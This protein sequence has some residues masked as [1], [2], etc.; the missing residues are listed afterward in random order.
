MH[1][2]EC[3]LRAERA[4][5]FGLIGC[6]WIVER[7]HAP[8]MSSVGTVEVVAVADPSPGR[9]DVVGDI[10]GLDAS[11]RHV[12]YRDLLARDDIEIVSIATPPTTHREIVQAAA[13]RGIH[14]ICEKPLATNLADCDAML[15]ACRAASV[16]L[17][18]YHN[19]LYLHGPRK[20]RELIEAGA[21][22]DVLATRIAGLALRPWV[23]NEA[24]RPG[25]RFSL[26]EGG[27]GALMDVGPHALYL[28]EALHGSRI[29]AV[30]AAMHYDRPGVDAS[31]FCELRLASGGLANVQVG[32][33]H[34][35]GAIVV[36]GSAGHL[37]VVFDERAGYF[38]APARA[39]RHVAGDGE[40][41]C[42]HALQQG[43]AMVESELYADLVA[44]LSG[45]SHAYP[46]YGEDGR[47]ALE[48]TLAAYAADA[49]HS[50]IQLPVP[51]D[52]PLYQRG[53]AAL[54]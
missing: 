43:Y 34:G 36:Y 10:L 23:G 3:P 41:T 32:W 15:E 48:V 18:V 8:T 42:T 13:A 31:A 39:I 21:V 7:N 22:G 20:L 5:R 26:D 4:V 12:D 6:G 9:T 33:R 54:V 30:T 27:G 38:G 25:W 35:E 29:S 1:L 46:A 17:A 45:E 51:P 53:V 37:E 11:A 24:Y 28:T 19:Y 16:T 49:R 40:P 52:D 2:N 50:W 14:V 44:T 47:R